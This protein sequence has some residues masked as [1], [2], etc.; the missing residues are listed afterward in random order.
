[1]SR[2]QLRFGDERI[3]CAKSPHDDHLELWMNHIV[4]PPADTSEVLQR[5][6]GEYQFELSGAP[7]GA[8]EPTGTMKED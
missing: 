4:G 7:A 1:M 5:H 8:C 6:N 2:H 3:V